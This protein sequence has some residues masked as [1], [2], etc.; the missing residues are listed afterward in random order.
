MNHVSC[1]ARVTGRSRQALLA[2]LLA[3]FLLISPPSSGQDPKSS[4]DK[5]PRKSDK[6]VAQAAV[7]VHFTDGSKLKLML[8][9]ERIEVTT[10]YGKLR[11]PD[12]DIHRIEFATRLAEDITKRIESAIT[13]LGSS[14]FRRRQAASAAL[15]KLKEKAYP[16]LLKAAKDKDAEVARRAGQLL[17]KIREEV[18]EDQL[19]NHPHDVV[20]TAD[21]KFTGRIEGTALKATTSQFGDVQLKLH[22]MRGLRSLAVPVQAEVAENVLADPGSLVHYQ[23]QIGKRFSFRVTGAAAGGLWG[24]DTYTTDSTLAMAAVHAGVLKVGQT[25]VV[26]VLIVAPP[27]AFAGSTRNGVTSNNYMAYPGAYQIIVK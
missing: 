5:G 18:P 21:S 6:S 7:E 20:Y 2:S 3:G 22:D 13:D 15:L 11:V 12:G 9:D 25:G 8:A 17:E 4:D 24:T 1:L 16:A 10:P 14:E 23:N 27:A 26:K 19:V